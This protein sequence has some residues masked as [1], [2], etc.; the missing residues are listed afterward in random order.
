MAKI[1]EIAT[2]KID[3]TKLTAAQ[4]LL[5]TVKNTKPKI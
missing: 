2:V 4:I 1:R 5:I 3:G